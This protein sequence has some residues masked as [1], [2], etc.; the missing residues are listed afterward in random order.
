MCITMGQDIVY[1]HDLCMTLAFYLKV[2]SGILCRFSI[3]DLW[4]S[5]RKTK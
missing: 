5:L 1:I 3:F 4:V 2:N